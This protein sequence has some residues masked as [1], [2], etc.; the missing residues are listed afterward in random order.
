M[1]AKNIYSILYYNGWF[2]VCFEIQ[3]Y[4]RVWFGYT[5]WEKLNETADSTKLGIYFYLLT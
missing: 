3:L 5:E 1:M 2:Y 4:K